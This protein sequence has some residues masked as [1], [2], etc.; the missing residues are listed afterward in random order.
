MRKTATALLVLGLTAVLAVPALAAQLLSETFTY[1]NGNLAG[2]G[3]WANFSGA[4]TDIQVVSGTAS[5]S[6][7]NANDDHV[8]FAAQP[9]N[10]KTY[11]CLT[12]RIPLVNGDPKPI[13]FAML[14]DAGTSNFVMAK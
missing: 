13:Y 2:N 4:V 7:P 14:K 6:G 11:A 1:P 8:L 10:A 12:V 5:G 9:T 3:G